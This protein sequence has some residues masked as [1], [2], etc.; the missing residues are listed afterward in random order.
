MA[1][2]ASMP[3]TPQ[4]KTPR[5][6]T[7]VVCESVPTSE[8]GKAT[9]LPSELRA[10]DHA[11][12]IFEIHL[13]AN[14]GVRRDHFEI[15]QA[16]LAPAQKSVA[17]DIALHFQFGVEGERIG[18]A[19]LIHLHGMVDHQFG[20]KQRIDFLRRRRPAS[21]IASRIAARSTTAGTPVK[22]CSSTR[23]GMKEI[24]FSVAPAAFVGSQPASAR[25]SSGVN[26]AVVLVAQQIFEQHFQGK[27]Q[28]RHVA[29]AGAR[30]RVQAINFKGIAADA[31][32]RASGE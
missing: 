32:I 20:G 14:A 22:S 4:P 15:L 30:E 10:E 27:R 8:S 2:S 26:E 7:I 28:A 9:Q 16:F 18:R 25:M 1:A 24:S 6:L 13:V 11:R 3:P 23:A 5:P 29:D 19:E 31:K 12:E 21:R 17:L